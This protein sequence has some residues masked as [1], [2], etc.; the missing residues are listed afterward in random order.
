[1]VGL[2]DH[3]AERLQNIDIDVLARRAD[4]QLI[5]LGR[6][7]L[8]GLLLVGILLGILLEESQPRVGMTDARWCTEFGSALSGLS[9][10]DLSHAPVALRIVEAGL[11][12]D[13]RVP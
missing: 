2:D 5:F 13:I 3:A 8:V 9:V 1:V 11:V 7:L 4:L 6:L 10:L 12:R